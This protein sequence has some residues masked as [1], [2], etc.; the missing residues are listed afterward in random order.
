M[1]TIDLKSPQGNAMVLMSYADK[2]SKMLK[3]DHDAIIADMQ[4]G[5]YDH[6]LDVFDEHFGNIYKL[7]NRDTEGEK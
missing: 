4:S 6:L 7:I 2:L 5:D 1:N 3:L